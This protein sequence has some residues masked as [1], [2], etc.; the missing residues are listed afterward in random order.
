MLHAVMPLPSFV[1]CFHI[2]S[3]P[4]SLRRLLLLLLLLR[5]R[6]RERVDVSANAKANQKHC[7]NVFGFGYVPACARVC[8]CVSARVCEL[9]RM[10]LQNS[11]RREK[12][13]PIFRSHRRCKMFL[14]WFRCCYCRRSHVKILLLHA[15][16]HVSV[17]CFCLRRRRSF[18]FSS[19]KS[20][21]GDSGSSVCRRCRALP[22]ILSS[23][24]L[25]HVDDAARVAWAVI[26]SFSSI[27]V[28]VV[29]IDIVS[30]Q[31]MFSI[32]CGGGAWNMWQNWIEIRIAFQWKMRNVEI[33]IFRKWHQWIGRGT[34]REMIQKWKWSLW[35]YSVV[36]LDIFIGGSMWGYSPL[37][38]ETIAHQ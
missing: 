15:R 18:L 11:N 3:V 31:F 30:G 6:G 12:K 21:F 17:L 7:L 9:L 5:C 27:A 1:C 14:Q 32:W 28:Y 26:L 16:A 29:S 4:L 13:K 23:S 24:M 38:N 2:F 8:V 36:R 33:E 10:L 34:K 22:P 20:F 37:S 19:E 25:C 35:V